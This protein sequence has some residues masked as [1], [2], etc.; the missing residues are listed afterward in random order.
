MKNNNK[1]TVSVIIPVFNRATIIVRAI[2]SVLQQTLSA[3]EIIIVDDGSTDNLSQTLKQKYSNVKTIK[4]LHQKNQGVSSARNNGIKK[5]TSDYIALLDSDDRWHK[6]KLSKQVAKIKDDLSI[7]LIHSNEVWY[8]DNAILNQQKK[9]QKYGGLIYDKCLKLCCISPS[10]VLIKKEV[11][12]E[13]GF[14]DETMPACE[15]YDYWLRFCSAKPVSFINDP[16]ID[17]YGGHSDQLSKKYPKMD[18]YR[19]YSL[20]K[21][22]KSK[23]LS[24]KNY[25]LT[26]ENMQYRLN[27]LI[28]GAIKRDKLD[29]IKIYQNLAKKYRILRIV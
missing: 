19:I 27:I 9:H 4:I 6:D 25:N 26:I 15:D 3:N 14:F 20:D 28:K 7:E 16:L 8:R 22:L 11:F 29:K 10:A 17:K 18:E 1:I 13:I 5:A 23:T 24:P 2:D 12:Y 21:M